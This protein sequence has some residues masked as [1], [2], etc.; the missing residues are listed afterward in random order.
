MLRRRPLLPTL[1]PSFCP[2]LFFHWKLCN[3]LVDFLADI[4]VELQHT[5]VK[6][7]IIPLSVFYV[8]DRRSNL[9][10]LHG[11][12]LGF[13]FTCTV[14]VSFSML[15]HTT[16]L[17]FLIAILFSILTCLIEHK[18]LQS[19]IHLLKNCVYWCV[20]VY[21]LFMI[22]FLSC[23]PW[24]NSWISSTRCIRLL[25]K[26]FKM[27]RFK[28]GPPNDFDSAVIGLFLFSFLLAFYQIHVMAHPKVPFKFIQFN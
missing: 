2:D 20:Y 10:L 23:M 8:N 9:F 4:A 1:W 18:A 19:A 21:L 22:E 7:S 14:C 13:Q 17:M 3:T 24:I 12:M 27:I 26:I 28:R 16:R 25:P 15:S 5:S 6:Y 11:S